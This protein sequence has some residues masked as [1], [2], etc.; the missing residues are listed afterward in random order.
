MNVCNKWLA[1]R[2]S[3]VCYSCLDLPVTRRT[4]IAN[5]RGGC[6]R[7]CIRSTRLDDVLSQTRATIIIRVD[8]KLRSYMCRSHSSCKR[9]S[10]GLIRFVDFC[11]QQ[12]AIAVVLRSPLPSEDRKRTLAA[13]AALSSVCVASGMLLRR[14]R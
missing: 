13:P 5:H 8:R 12:H 3:I 9:R 11:R 14:R 1:G 10:F 7:R 4:D 6:F 2:S